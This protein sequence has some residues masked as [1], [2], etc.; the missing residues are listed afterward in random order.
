MRTPTHTQEHAHTQIYAYTHIQTHTHTSMPI[1]KRTHTHT[2]ICTQHTHTRTHTHIHTRAHTQ[3]THRFT[4][5]LLPRVPRRPLCRT[6]CPK[7]SPQTPSHRCA[8]LWK[9]LR[10]RVLRVAHTNTGTR[11]VCFHALLFVQLL[12][13]QISIL[14]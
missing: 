11:T 12:F 2:H 7:R 6:Y 5:F 8:L 14:M 10:L 9:G 3:H 1:H 13:V 4:R